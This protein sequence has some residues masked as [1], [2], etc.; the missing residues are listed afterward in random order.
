MWLKLCVFYVFLQVLSSLKC[1][2]YAGYFK[3]NKFPTFMIF[4]IFSN[5]PIA[6]CDFCIPRTSRFAAYLGSQMAACIWVILYYHNLQLLWDLCNQPLPRLAVI[7][8]DLGGPMS[9]LYAGYSF[10]PFFLILQNHIYQYTGTDF[11]FDIG[12]PKVLTVW[13]LF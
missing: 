5:N 3:L 6:G 10:M 12:D 1:S 8:I 7:D 11:G 4:L 2:L 13:G 9:I